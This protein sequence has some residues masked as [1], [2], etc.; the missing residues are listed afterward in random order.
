MRNFLENVGVGFE[1]NVGG[2]ELSSFKSG[3]ELSLVFYPASAERVVGLIGVLKNTPI[4]F[5]VLG[6]GTNTLIPD[7]GYDGAVVCLKDFK[8]IR[9]A[10]P[11]EYSGNDIKTA[12][13]VGVSSSELYN[14]SLKNVARIVAEGGAALPKLSAF[15]LENSL[16]GLE[17]LCGIPGSVGGGVYMNAGAYGKEIGDVLA[18]ADVLEIKSGKVFRLKREALEFSYRNSIFQRR[19]GEYVVLAAAFDTERGEKEKIR[20]AV[21]K[22]RKK[23]A[24][25]QPRQPS[26]GSVFRRID[27]VIPPILIDKAGLKGYNIGGARVSEKHAGFIVNSGGAS[28]SDF[29]ALVK[30]IKSVVY[31]KYGVE[32]IEEIEILE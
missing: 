1:T 10:S 21:L 25:S 24:E 18:Y 28:S 12:A 2:K 11:S 19:R 13:E 26:L 8:G 27:G 9:L 5:R 20:N 32:L 4:K 7:A 15:A 29:T 14:S 31:E 23:R 6:Y 17:F 30:Y 22:F 16:T 3:G